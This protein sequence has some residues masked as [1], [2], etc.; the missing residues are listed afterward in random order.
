MMWVTTLCLVVGISLLFLQVIWACRFAQRYLPWARTPA[1]QEPLPRTTV[2]LCLRGL[3]PSL[4]PCLN[5]LLDQDYPNYEIRIV[6]D[7]AE[8]PAWE[9]V[10]ALQPRSVQPCVK[11]SVLVNPP[12]TCSLKLSA[13]VQAIRSLDES[14]E[15]VALFDADVIPYRQWLR[16]LIRPL[17]D[18][19]IGA[20]SGVRWY[21][22]RGKASW[23]TLVRSIWN[24]GACPQMDAL[25]IP[26]GGS[27]TFRAELFRQSDLL[28]RW[29]RSFAED[30]GS[31]R[32]LR[33]L[34]LQLRLVPEATM[35]N[36]ETI[37]MPGCYHFIRRQLLNARLYHESW[38]AILALNL[39]ALLALPVALVPAL[40]KLSAG[41]WGWLAG[42]G[43]ALGAYVA[44]MV[45]PLSWIDRRVNRLVQ[46]RGAP[47]YPYCWKLLLAIP[48][49][50]VV[51]LAALTSACFLRTVEWRGIR[52][53]VD[54]SGSVR[55]LEYR[56]YREVA[57]GATSDKSLV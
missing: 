28:E 57:Q 9:I 11:V 5:G 13:L 43:V 14:T 41:H 40:V 36:H 26:W 27:M 39:G 56:P 4:L 46:A 32:V 21:M 8:D 54:G 25:H 17:A 30:T 48:L 12:N 23:G 42:I 53:A 6:I 31:H 44:G 29:A 15:V 34:G 24:A 1:D 33:S 7:S 35:V 51:Y 52:Y 10:S 49:T 50:Q 55:L 20:T 45:L 22:P 18:P 19:R 2:L 37:D 38:P 16:D 3:D 47:P